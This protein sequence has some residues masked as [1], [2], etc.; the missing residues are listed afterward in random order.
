[1]SGFIPDNILEE[2][3]SRCDIV[4]IISQYIPLRRAGANYKAG[5]PF[6]DE[7]T[8]SFMVSPAKQ[9][10]HC[11]GCGVGGDVFGFIKQYEHVDF[12]DAVKLLAGKTGITIPEKKYTKDE[13]Q[14]SLWE[15]NKFA[16]NFYHK[17]LYD[18]NAG[19]RCYK[20]LKDRGIKDDII[21]K[22][23]LGYASSGN[24]FY[25]EAL[26]RGYTTDVLLKTGLI[27]R[28]GNKLSDMFRN[29][30]VFPI[31]NTVGKVVGF[32]G[33]VLDNSL[34]KYINSPE[35]PL[36]HKGKILYGLDVSK[37]EISKKERAIVCEGFFDCIRMYQEG[38][39]ETVA[40]AGTALTK[41][42]VHLLHRYTSCIIVA[43]DGDLAGNQAA[44][45]KLEIFLEEGIQV[46]I[47]HIPEGYDPDS[48]I[49]DKGIDRFKTLIDDAKDIL[50]TKLFK[51][52]KEYPIDK[53]DSKIKI[54]SEMLSD[55]I[56]IDN[57]IKRRL[58]V[59]KIAEKL[60]VP[61]DGIWIELRKVKKMSKDKKSYKKKNEFGINRM[62]LNKETSSG[63]K[64]LV[65]VLLDDESL[66]PNIAYRS[67]I[68]FMKHQGYK[69]IVELIVKLKKNDQWKGPSSLISCMEDEELIKLV[70]EISA[71]EIP[72]GLDKERVARD[73]IHDIK[74]RYKESRI[75]YLLT[76]MQ[77][78]EKN[79]GD[80]S[81]LIQEIDA[82]RKDIIIKK[83]VGD[84]NEVSSVIDE[85]ASAF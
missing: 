59:G 45:N 69:Q 20:Y 65:Q 81:S 77:K 37:S 58:F 31:R 85:I 53:T 9:I 70:S 40:V 17:L 56:K 54:I 83:K 64:Q 25:R 35:T 21:K 22:F 3:R 1:M 76:E 26:K 84:G 13:N 29:R 75:K 18:P 80:V 79:K 50:D 49:K 48:F 30:L 19:N 78:T 6:H 63:E 71:E 52:C 4:E 27:V 82:L 5:C 12:I 39:Y 23:Q 15:V 42:Q 10:F 62:V 43:F 38:I 16:C 34:P 24:E 44:M 51:L 57:E 67:V 68:S 7:K 28:S 46:K 66:Y 32:S 33:R 61:E 8:A 2:I 41:D 60:D 72:E 36:F 73:C 47:V 74:R 11:F 55:I 14:K